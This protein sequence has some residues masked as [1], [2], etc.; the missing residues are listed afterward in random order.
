MERIGSKW[1]KV[2]RIDQS[3]LNWTKMNGIDLCLPNCYVDVEH[4]NNKY[5]VL[6]FRYYIDID[7]IYNFKSSKPNSKLLNFD[8]SLSIS[9]IQRKVKFYV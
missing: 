6:A 4:N 2:D 3:K 8:P 7:M 1:T 5:Y 9:P